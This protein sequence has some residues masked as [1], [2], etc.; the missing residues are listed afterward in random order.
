MKSKQNQD[1][2]EKAL[3]SFILR[4][5]PVTLFLASR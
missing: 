3:V 5:R 4:S 1:T 2:P